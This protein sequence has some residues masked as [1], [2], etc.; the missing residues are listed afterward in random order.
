MS[1]LKRRY[2]RLMVLFWSHMMM[3][4]WIGID[5]LGKTCFLQ[6]VPNFTLRTRLASHILWIPQ[7]LILVTNTHI[8]RS[9]ILLTSS[10]HIVVSSACRTRLTQIDSRIP[11]RILLITVYL[12]T[13]IHIKTE[14]ILLGTN[15][16]RLDTLSIFLI[17][18]LSCRTWLNT[19]LILIGPL[20][21]WSTRLALSC[22]LIEWW[23]FWWTLQTLEIH[24]I[25]IWRGWRA[26]WCC[27]SLLARFSL[28]VIELIRPTCYS[29]TLW[30]ALLCILIKN[31]ILCTYPAQLFYRII[32]RPVITTLVTRIRHLIPER[33]LRWTQWMSIASL[34][35]TFSTSRVPIV[36]ISTI[37][38]WIFTYPCILVPCLIWIA[39]STTF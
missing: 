27:T 1:L 39:F 31:L 16:I 5:W 30:R 15:L 8:S 4:V 3:I 13:F 28:C 36:S 22:F 12:N 14:R 10:N 29:I 18:F 24:W 2:V 19:L 34:S 21:V 17:P 26:H 38:W 37:L 32:K 20:K 6:T 25:P 35:Y 9:R 33:S 23:C 7:W 11:V